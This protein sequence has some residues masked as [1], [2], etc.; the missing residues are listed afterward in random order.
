LPWRHGRPHA[1]PQV[2]RAA[3]F[4]PRETKAALDYALR[5]G[6]LNYALPGPR[7]VTSARDGDDGYPILSLLTC[8]VFDS[9]MRREH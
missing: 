1:R 8:M 3:R 4:H 2:P 9:S 6:A 7:T 5:I